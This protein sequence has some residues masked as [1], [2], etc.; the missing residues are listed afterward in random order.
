MLSDLNFLAIVYHKHV[1]DA[2]ERE[3]RNL[4]L[5]QIMGTRMESDERTAI[6]PI[7]KRLCRR[8][9]SCIVRCIGVR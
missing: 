8:G 7:A 2:Y 1:V 4:L 5:W 3:R 6:S 9:F